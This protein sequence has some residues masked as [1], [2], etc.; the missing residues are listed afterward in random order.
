MRL[1][2]SNWILI[3]FI[4]WLPIQGV[5]AAVLSVCAQDDFSTHH[6]VTLTAA[7]DSHHH[8]DCHK[9]SANGSPLVTSLPCDDTSCNAYNNTPILSDHAAP[10]LTN[11]PSVM[12]ALNTGFTSF[13]PEQPQRPPLA[14][15]L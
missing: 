6:D 4:L 12:M 2:L 13:V 11:E 9:Q 1:Y 8:A 7:V 14:D 5:T 15:T 10:L 3:F